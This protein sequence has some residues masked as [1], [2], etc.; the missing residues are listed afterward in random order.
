MTT[1]YRL[2]KETFPDRVR[3][4]TEAYQPVTKRW[5]FVSDSLAVTETEARVLYSK[6][7]QQSSV[8][9]TEILDEAEG[10]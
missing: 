10:T 7:V 3:Y 8:A 6:I 4:S 2:V 9:I 5:C 1:K